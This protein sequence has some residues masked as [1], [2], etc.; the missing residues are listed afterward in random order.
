MRERH[1]LEQVPTLRQLRDSRLHLLL[2]Q[3][4]VALAEKVFPAEL[5]RLGHT[6]A[7]PNNGGNRQQRFVR[8]A[9]VDQLLSGLSQLVEPSEALHQIIGQLAEHGKGHIF[10]AEPMVCRKTRSRDVSARTFLRKRTPAPIGK[11]DVAA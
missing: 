1:G 5:G 3:F 4:L 2:C 7:Q 6:L 8:I 11:A 9:P 10:T